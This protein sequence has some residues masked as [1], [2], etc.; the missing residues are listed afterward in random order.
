MNL[1]VV[2]CWYLVEDFQD[3]KN[4]V[5][6]AFVFKR[7]GVSRKWHSYGSDEVRGKGYTE[8]WCYVLVRNGVWRESVSC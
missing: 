5:I 6:I 2:N 3:A 1:S 4:D 7:R 8:K